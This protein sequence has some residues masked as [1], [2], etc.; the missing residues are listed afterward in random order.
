MIWLENTPN[1]A[2]V[3]LSGDQNDLASLNEAINLVVGEEGEYPGYEHVRL[4]ILGLCDELYKAA[5]GDREVILVP[6]FQERG[7]MSVLPVDST[8]NNVYFQ[9]RVTWPDLLFL[10]FVLNDF[11]EL[12]AK[13]RQHFW[14]STPAR[15]RQFQSVIGECLENT[16]GEHKFRLLKGSLTPNYIGYYENYVTQYIDYLNIEFLKMDKDKRLAHVSIAAKRVANRDSKYVKI[17]GRIEMLAM[18]EGVSLST[19]EYP[20][21]YPEEFEW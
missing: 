2:G 15:I 11:I 14:D 12:S 20:G 19:I 3:Y 18:Q 1:Y 10:G 4:R 6:I 21:S 8:R 13:H 17:K 7:N 5:M 16:V 9:V